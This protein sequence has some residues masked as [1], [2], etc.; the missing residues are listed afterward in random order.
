MS[1]LAQQLIE[2]SLCTQNP[3]LNLGNCGL[4]GTEKILNRLVECEHLETLV[5]SNS[6]HEFDEVRQEWRYRE[7]QNKGNK[8]LLIQL[9]THLPIS[10]QKLYTGVHSSSFSEI[11]EIQD[12]TPLKNL[13]EL[14]SLDLRNNLIRDLK[15]IQKLTQLTYL[16]LSQNQIVDLKPIQELKQLQNLILNHNRIKD[17]SPIQKLKQ[18]KTLN[19]SHNYINNLTPIQELRELNYLYL[20]DNQITDL[21]PIQELKQL[22][23]LALNHSHVNNLNPIQELKQLTY[24]DLSNNQINDL[25][26]IRELKQLIHLY[27]SN[28]QINDLRPIR[29]LK[30]LTHLYLSN[31][32]IN[33]LQFIRELKQLT[34]LYLSNNQINDLQ[35]IRELKQLTHLYLKH[36]QITYIPTDFLDEMD[37]LFV[38]RLTK[39]PIQNV[40]LEILSK[41]VNAIRNH[42]QSIAKAEDQY[43]LN[44]AKVIFVGVGEVGKSEL[45]EA[46]SEASYH[47]EEGRASTSGIRIKP[48]VLADCTKDSKNFDLIAHIWDFAGQEINYGTH[49]FFL[50]KNS[51]YLFLWDARKGENQSRFDYWLQVIALLSN[52]S[53][54]FVVQNK[55]DLYQSEVDQQSWK[56]TFPNIVDFRKTSCKN[57]TGIRELR[58]AVKNELQNLPHIGEVWNKHRVAARKMLEAQDA[59]YI[60]YATYLQI[61]MQ[62]GVNV[63]DAGYLSYQLHDIGVILYFENDLALQD[64]MV[65][66][67]EWATKAAYCLLDNEKED[68]TIKAGRF[69]RNLLSQLW[70]DPAFEGKYPFLLRLM[71]RFELVFQLHD[72]EEYI[73]PELL[74]IQA[75]EKASIFPFSQ[76][77]SAKRLR[78]E[79]HYEFMPRGIFSR[80]ICRIHEHIYQ[81]L[82][83][84]YGI[85]LTYENTFAQVLWDNTTTIKTIKIAIVGTEADK[86]LFLIR[87][88]LGHIHK[89]L[90]NPPFTEKVPCICA[91][92]QS[93]IPHL[94]NYVTLQKYQQKN[95][96][97]IVCEKS[98][99]DV[100]IKTLLQ[101]ILDDI[102]PITQ[103]LLDMINDYQ[104][105]DF[106]KYLEHLKV[107]EY[108]IAK[109]RAEFIDGNDSFKFA[110]RLKVW[111]LDYFKHRAGRV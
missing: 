108:Q 16:D 68:S 31:N 32:R 26:P 107:E 67:P 65:L 88:E 73:I 48:W 50:T 89:K 35:F 84:K 46:L 23:T 11:W 59:N 29:R 18:L 7:S 75:P 78:F 21:Q 106:F 25:K 102:A 2:E 61:C 92:C 51:V 71:E 105:A 62:C 94:Y 40:P 87:N 19:L 91:E 34:H 101:G 24:L 44:E 70:Q 80:F 45:S 85:I 64:T 37:T 33:D 14:K 1:K 110:E 76:T 52:H 79:Y 63:E 38:L 95:R 5:F 72:S 28:N 8:N 111:V 69:H 13:R 3:Y 90:N 97:T 104:V 22:I 42:L 60:N 96:A 27:L 93:S 83:W 36:N 109:L 41:S 82:F 77:L 100:S 47:F 4:D 58:A 99:E 86:L 56:Q 15:N 10:L 81:Q 12:L 98:L 6:W 53:P 103:R 30:Q 54:V 43:A 9:P 39:N 57:G 20:S 49:Q 17:S 66:K 74:P 55:V